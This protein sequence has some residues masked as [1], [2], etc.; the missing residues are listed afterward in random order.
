MSRGV[1]AEGEYL[2]TDF[3][4]SAEADV[5]LSPMTLEFIT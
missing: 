1:G 2:K 5:G 4:L 3:L